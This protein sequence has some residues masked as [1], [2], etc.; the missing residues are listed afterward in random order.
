MRTPLPPIPDSERTPLVLALLE[1]IHQQNESIAQLQDEITRLKGLKTRPNIRPSTLEQ[2]PPQQP[3]EPPPDRPRP[4]SAKRHKTAQLPIHQTQLCPPAVLPS[5]CRF[6]E[7]QDYVVQDLLLRPHNLCYRREC[8]RTPDGATVRGQLPAGVREGGHF[9]PTLKAFLL[10]QY[11]RQRVTQ[12]RLLSQVRSWGVD[13]SAGQLNRLLTEGHERFHQD[14]D[15]LLPA[16]LTACAYVQ[17]D[18][19]AA[20]HQGQNGYCTHIGND[21][22][23]WFASTASKSRLNFLEL[24]R[25]GHTDYVLGAEALAYLRQR[26]A[27]PWVVQLLESDPQRVFATAAAWQEHLDRLGITQ[28]SP[29]RLATEGA[30]LGS[31]LAQGVSAE[32]VIVSDDAGQFHV[33]VHALCWVHAERALNQLLALTE[34]HR[35]AVAAVRE[36]FWQLYQDLKGYRADPRPEARVSLRARFD[37]LVGQETCY[38]RLNRVL[39]QWQRNGDELLLVLAHPEVPVHNN[40][41]ERDI[42]EYVIWRKVSGGTRSA[43]GRRCRDTF[44]SLAKTCKKLGVSFWDYLRD[45]LSAAPVLPTLSELV[46]QKA[47][48]PT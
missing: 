43:L 31:V 22:F 42:R 17:V 26:D 12:P 36:Q 39:G 15:A 4:G 11:Y 5:G 1:I 40:L 9:G 27:P 16:G 32:L 6:Q 33:F 10:D 21:F 2:P 46:R 34:E 7:Y 37:R 41:S 23:A 3:P 8:W 48:A 18:D 38:P 20:R 47:L 30:L 45:R 29:R 35:V 19:T 14:K 13:L 44:L 24:L 28:E 25:G